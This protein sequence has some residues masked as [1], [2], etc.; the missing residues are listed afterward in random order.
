MDSVRQFG[1]TDKHKERG[2]DG[3]E[4]LKTLLQE[5][6]VPVVLAAALDSSVVEGR[7]VELRR[8]AKRP[9]VVAISRRPDG[10]RI[11][12]RFRHPVK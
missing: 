4:R 1:G 7:T 6:L 12:H 9:E 8:T 3:V 10:C 11:A 5:E 2:L